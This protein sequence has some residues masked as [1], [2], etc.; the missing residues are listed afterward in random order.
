MEISPRSGPAHEIASASVCSTVYF[1]AMRIHFFASFLS[2]SL[3][4][5]PSMIRCNLIQWFRKILK[6]SKWAGIFSGLITS[7]LGHFLASLIASCSLFFVQ[8]LMY[9]IS[10]HEK[11]EPSTITF[12]KFC[13]DF[14]S[15]FHNFSF[16]YVVGFSCYP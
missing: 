8:L 12:I 13:L 10:T 2:L 15:Q 3:A 7:W 4:F 9:I 14:F 16:L 5:F 11:D 6:S 1:L